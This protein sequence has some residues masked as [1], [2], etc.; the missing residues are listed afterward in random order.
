MKP[1]HYVVIVLIAG[2]LLAGI[3]IHFLR[4]ERTVMDSSVFTTLFG[5][6]NVT[7]KP[8]ET[9][10]F[11]LEWRITN[12]TPRTISGNGYFVQELPS[13][14]RVCRNL[15]FL[16][17]WSSCYQWVMG[18]EPVGNYSRTIVGS[19]VQ[20]RFGVAPGDCN[21]TPLA[22][23]DWRYMELNGPGKYYACVENIGNETVRITVYYG[24]GVQSEERPYGMCGISLLIMGALLIS[25]AGVIYYT[26][27]QVKRL[28]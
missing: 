3:G 18:V 13:P 22:V 23:Q 8:G 6:I 28:S 21:I 2:V 20:V 11:V 14:P 1:E 26:G 25:A 27:T 16:H 12:S 5:P 24:L 7:L 10:V 15:L 4:V 19:V 17:I 9:R